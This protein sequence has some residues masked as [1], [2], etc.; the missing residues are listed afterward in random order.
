MVLE[1]CTEGI[2]YVGLG[3]Y[4]TFWHPIVILE[5]EDIGGGSGPR[6]FLQQHLQ[7]DTLG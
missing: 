2:L 6:E 1:D 5:A 3:F 4:G 7:P